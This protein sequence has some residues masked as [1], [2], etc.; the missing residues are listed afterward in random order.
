M[1][2]EPRPVPPYEGEINDQ[3]WYCLDCMSVS[4][5]RLAMSNHWGTKHAEANE[6]CVDGV[7]ICPGWMLR[8]LRF[9]RLAWIEDQ[10]EKLSHDM[11]EGF[12]AD[13]FVAE[14]E[15]ADA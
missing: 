14:A 1:P 3:A 9:K 5:G 8:V 6:P 12:T 13:D 7:D 15:I 11:H 10:A 4:N 2:D